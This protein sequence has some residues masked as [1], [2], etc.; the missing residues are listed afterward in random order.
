MFRLRLKMQMTSLSEGLLTPRSPEGVFMRHFL[1]I[2]LLTLSSCTTDPI[3]L[4]N[5]KT[6]E[7]VT[8]GQHYVGLAKDFKMEGIAMEEGQCI[9]DY[10]EQGYIRVPTGEK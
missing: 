4:K 6:G 7:I 5:K 3:Y 1:L 9:N 8:C 2:A 10:K